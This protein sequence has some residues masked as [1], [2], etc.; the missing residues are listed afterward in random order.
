MRLKGGQGL[1]YLG[2]NNKKLFVTKAITLLS[3]GLQHLRVTY[4]KCMRFL[5]RFWG[6]SRLTNCVRV[7]SSRQGWKLNQE[8]Q[9]S[10]DGRTTAWPNNVVRLHLSRPLFAAS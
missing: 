5:G 6:V 1:L 4:A 10:V 2:S 7:G 3:L 8:V 9:Y